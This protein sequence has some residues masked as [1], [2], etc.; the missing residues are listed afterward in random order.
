MRFEKEW[1]EEYWKSGFFTFI[2]FFS[3]GISFSKEAAVWAGFVVE[4]IVG[5][6]YEKMKG[7]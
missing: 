1:I 7:E 2:V 6:C 5:G 4:F 3:P